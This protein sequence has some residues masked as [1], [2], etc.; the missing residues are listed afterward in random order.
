MSIGRLDGLT[1]IG[2]AM[3]RLT[4]DDGHRGVVDLAAVAGARSALL[5]L[6]DPDVFAAATLAD[7][8]WSVDWPS[9]IDFGSAQLRRWAEEQA[10]EA[11]PADA[12]RQ[13]IAHHGF[14]LDHA[15]EA[16]GLSRRTIAYYL[17]GEQPIPKTVMLATIGF[18]RRAA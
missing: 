5:P 16:L 3:L 7:D 13:W 6:L 1:V 2:P 4:W 9:G 11:M 15:A 14:T 18:D 10:G 12:F 17:S 8:G